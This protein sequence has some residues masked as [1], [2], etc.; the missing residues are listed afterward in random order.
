MQLPYET[1]LFYG[2]ISPTEAS[3][4]CF[5]RNSVLY[6]LNNEPMACT[7]IRILFVQPN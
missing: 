5:L 4:V 1:V 2:I 6:N 3:M 7:I